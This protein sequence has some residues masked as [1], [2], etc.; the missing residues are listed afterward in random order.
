MKEPEKGTFSIRFSHETTEEMA[1]EILKENCS[2]M[3][4]Y[5]YREQEIGNR[6]FNIAVVELC[7]DHLDNFRRDKRVLYFDQL[8]SLAPHHKDCGNGGCPNC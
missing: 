5:K 8:L 3:K 4:L 7:V 2:H 6:K 1:K